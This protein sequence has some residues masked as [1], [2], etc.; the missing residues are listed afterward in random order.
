MY[1]K[2]GELHGEPRASL[3]GLIVHTK[4]AQSLNASCAVQH[5]HVRHEMCLGLWMNEK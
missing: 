3:A 5:H 2:A 1:G 4:L